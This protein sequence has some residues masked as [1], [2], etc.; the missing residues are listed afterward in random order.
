MPRLIFGLFLLAIR[1]PLLAQPANSDCSTAAL[2]CAGQP[3]AGN[4]TGGGA[5]PIFCPGTSNALW[6]SFTTNSQGG[7]VQLD[8]S[9]IDCPD[10]PGMDSTLS[11]VVLAG[12]EDCDLAGFAPVSLCEDDHASFSFLTGPLLPGTRYWVVVSGVQGP[13]STIPA[14]CGFQIT[15]SGEGADVV[16]VDFSAGA[17]VTIGQGQIVQ[18]LATGGTT[19]QWSP[20][21]G[22]SGNNVSNPFAQPS[23]TTLYTV[24]TVVNGCTF[25]DQVLVEVVRLIDPPNT[26]TPNG[27]GINDVWLIDGME[28]YPNAEV[29]VYDRWGQRVYRSVGY[30]DPWDGTN[31]GRSLP[32]ATYYY[33]I[34]LNQ[35]EGR[36]PPYTG[37]ITIIR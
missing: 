21:S 6:Y 2:L 32:T 29:L 23:E 3:Q 5:A 15:L 25:E 4:N 19:Y 20:T 33:H 17:D 31:G 27:D 24:T 37:S 1:L 22:L 13:G 26:F 28:E 18:L 14:Q 35:L 12:N 8:I 9:A 10:V 30:R 11:V 7:S 36:S 34:Q 16:G